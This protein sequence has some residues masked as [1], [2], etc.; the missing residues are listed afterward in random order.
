[1]FEVVGLVREFAGVFTDLPE[2]TTLVSHYIRLITDVPVSSN[3]YVVSYRVRKSL[4]TD[5]HKMIDMKV[6]RRSELPYAS[7]VVVVR[8]RDGTNRI[9]VDYRRLNRITIPDPEPITPMVELVQKL[10][11]G[12][13]F[14]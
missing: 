13:F 10:G 14:T 11:K 6:T 4:Q 12:R 3:P 5:I 9:C 8:K 7:P 2:T 1:M